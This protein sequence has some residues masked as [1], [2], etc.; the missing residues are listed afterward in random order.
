MA[1]RC[2]DCIYLNLSDKREGS[3]IL[4]GSYTEYYCR[5]CGKYKQVT[6]SCSYFREDMSKQS[7][8]SGCFITTVVVEK[9]H[10]NDKT[11]RMLNVLRTFRSK[12]SKDQE[13]LLKTYDVIGPK[14]AECLRLEPTEYAYRIYDEKLMPIAFAILSEDDERAIGLYVMLVKDFAKKYGIDEDIND[15]EY[16]KDSIKGHG[17]ARLHKRSVN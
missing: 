15:Y 6:D 13:Y 12:I 3:T 5:D 9:C 14:I 2:G 4:G 7:S 10:F 11:S 17:R 16:E 8:G 1:E